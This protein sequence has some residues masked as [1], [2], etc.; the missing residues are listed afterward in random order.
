MRGI[1][2]PP[3]LAPAQTLRH[4]HPAGAVLVLLAVAVPVKLHLH[5]AVLVGVDLLPR[6][7]DHDG[8]LRPLNHRLGRDARRAIRLLAVQ[9]GEP[10]GVDIFPLSSRA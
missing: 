2:I 8:G 3:H 5:A 7:T 4:A 1:W 6:G 10:A 9:G